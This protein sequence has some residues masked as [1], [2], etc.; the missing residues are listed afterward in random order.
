MKIALAPFGLREYRGKPGA[1]GYKE[2]IKTM[3]RRVRDIGFDGIEMGAPEGFTAREYKDYMDEIG[4]A[5]TSANG[6]RDILEREDLSDVIEQCKIMGASNTMIGSPTPAVLGNPYELGRFIKK[7]NRAGKA[8]IQEGIT[9]SY[10]NHAID[11]SKIN[12]RIMFEHIIEGT[13]EG[14]VFFEPDTH[15]IQAGGGHVITWLKRLRGRMRV[16]HFKDYGIDP[17]SDHAFLEGTHKLFMEIGE[18]NLNWQG[19]IGECKEQ[20]IGWCSVE[21]DECR[22]P[23]YESAAISLNN[24]RK[25]GV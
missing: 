13:E 7:L 11:F 20:G 4:L 6:F 8:L 21:Q 15:W 10:H 14:S 19:I 12:G 23:P 16:V 1:P 9:L 24:L 25:M 3:L 5:V 18:G 2:G 22:R 17:Y